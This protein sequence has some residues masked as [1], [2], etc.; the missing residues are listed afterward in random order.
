MISKYVKNQNIECGDCQKVLGSLDSLYKVANVFLEM[1][2]ELAIIT[3]HEE[4][5][6]RAGK[7][8]DH[9]ELIAFKEG[10]GALQAFMAK[11]YAERMQIEGV[12]KEEEN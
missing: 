8:F 4:L 3:L 7:A 10:L 11:C 2:E 5:E 9:N 6:W 1:P 12:G